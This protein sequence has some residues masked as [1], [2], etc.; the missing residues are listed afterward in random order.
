MQKLSYFVSAFSHRLKPPPRDASQFTR[1]LFHPR[2]D[3]RIP[4][5]SPVKP[6]QFCPHRCSIF[7]V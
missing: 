1:I 5:D 7:S 4:L 2:L 6:K 3:G